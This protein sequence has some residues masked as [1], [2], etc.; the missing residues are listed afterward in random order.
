MFSGLLW[1]VQTS[2]NLGSKTRTLIFKVYTN[3]LL[4]FCYATAMPPLC[5]HCTVS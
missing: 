5:F 4:L 2:C 1:G 3:E